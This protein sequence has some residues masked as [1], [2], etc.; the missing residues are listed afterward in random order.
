[1][2]ALWVQTWS[3][4]CLCSSVLP[5]P[6][7]SQTVI[8][9]LEIQPTEAF[10]SRFP[11]VNGSSCPG[12]VLMVPD[13]SCGPAR[14]GVLEEQQREIRRRKTKV[15]SLR[16]IP[17]TGMGPVPVRYQSTVVGYYLPDGDKEEPLK[18]F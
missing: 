17:E 11:I 15:T 4:L 12:R 1:M 8:R 2:K 13:G 5:G 3:W 16:E 7:G 9:G 14:P 18:G 10:F 6:A